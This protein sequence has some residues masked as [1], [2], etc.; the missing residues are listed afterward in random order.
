MSRV[1]K[2]RPRTPKGLRRGFDA[3]SLASFFDTN[4][5]LLAFAVLFVA[6]ADMEKP[7][8]RADAAR[9]I[10]SAWFETLAKELELTPEIWQH[11]ARGVSAQVK[12]GETSR[13]YDSNQRIA[14]M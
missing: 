1:Y 11:F 13:A 9:F 14:T 3:V 5:E 12:Q 10:Y 4:L 6:F 7:T 2:R 8:L